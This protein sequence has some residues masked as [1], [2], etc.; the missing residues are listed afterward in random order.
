MRMTYVGAAFL[1]AIAVIPTAVSGTMN[2]PFEI[3]AFLGG[4]GPAPA[5][6]SSLDSRR[7]D[8][9]AAHLDRSLP[10]EPDGAISLVARAWV[11]RG[12]AG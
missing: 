6:V 9:L 11:V 5:Y 12:V 8:A 7:R 1:C 10:R 3:S 4:T 2:I